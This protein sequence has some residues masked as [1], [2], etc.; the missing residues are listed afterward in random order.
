MTDTPT[1]TP[2]TTVIHVHDMRDGDIYIGRAV[3][4]RRLKASP[5]ANP[6]KLGKDGDRP[7]IMDKYREY[8]LTRPDLLARLPELR[9]RRLA[10]W[11]APEAC[12]GDILVEL[13]EQEEREG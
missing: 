13:I 5:F 11:C 6:F 4:R 2:T 1:A 12:H 9:G 8:I 7:E 10:C 3:S